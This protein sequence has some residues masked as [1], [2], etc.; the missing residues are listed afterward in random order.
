MHLP[1][2]IKHDVFVLLMFMLSLPYKILGHL[3]QKARNV[4]TAL[5]EITELFH[6]R[7]FYATLLLIAV[8][9]K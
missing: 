6:C 3:I 1:C 4:L 9:W 7:L 8:M 2:K 5:I